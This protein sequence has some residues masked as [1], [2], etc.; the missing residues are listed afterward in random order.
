MF[1]LSY[2]SSLNFAQPSSSFTLS[3]DDVIPLFLFD[4]KRVNENETP[5]SLAKELDDAIGENQDFSGRGANEAETGGIK[6]NVVGQDFNEIH[7]KVKMSTQLGN[8]KK[9]YSKRLVAPI[10]SLRLLN[11][12][13]TGNR[14]SR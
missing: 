10:A 1:S 12:L 13:I 7:F 6:L 11:P 5:K 2:I 4:G 8:L 14:T 9:C 3:D